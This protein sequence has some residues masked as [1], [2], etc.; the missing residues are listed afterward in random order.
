MER[1]NRGPIFYFC[2]GAL[3]SLVSIEAKIVRWVPNTNTNNPNNW[4]TGQVPCSN[5]HIHF[6]ATSPS[7]Y[8][9]NNLTTLEIVL[10][11]NGEVIL[12]DSAVLVF[13]ASVSNDATCKEKNVTFVGVEAKSWFD[14]LN[15]CEMSNIDG[16][17]LSSPPDRLD[18]DRV[19]CSSDSVVFPGDASYLVQLENSVDIQVGMLTIANQA[20]TTQTFQRYLSSEAGRKQFIRESGTSA[21][22]LTVLSKTCSQTEPT[23]C[24]CANSQDKQIKERVCQV[25]NG[26]CGTP[27]CDQPL[28]VDEHCCQ[29][30]GSVLLLEFGATTRLQLID[31]LAKRTLSDLGDKKEGVKVYVSKSHDEEHIQIVVLDSDG[32]DK[33][34]PLG[35]DIKTK[36]DADMSDKKRYGITHITIRESG[37]SNS[38]AQAQTGYKEMGA[39]NIVGIVIGLIA[40]LVIVLLAIYCTSSSRRPLK[41]FIP[42][43]PV[44]LRRGSSDGRKR[45]ADMELAHSVMFNNSVIFEAGGFDNPNFDPSLQPQRE[46]VE[47]HPRPAQYRVSGAAEQVDLGTAKGSFANPVYGRSVPQ[48]SKSEA[49]V[50]ATSQVSPLDDQSTTVQ[51]TVQFSHKALKD[52]RASKQSPAKSLLTSILSR[53]M[54]AKLTDDDN[55]AT[56]GQTSDDKPEHDTDVT[57]SKPARSPKKSRKEAGTAGESESKPDEGHEKKSKKSKTGSSSQMHDKLVEDS[58]SDQDNKEEKKQESKKRKEK[59]SKKKDED[60]DGGDLSFGNP[61]YM[62]EDT[63]RIKWEVQDQAA[64]AQEKPTKDKS[65]KEKQSKEKPKKEKPSK[66]KPSSFANP[67]FE[68]KP[69][70]AVAESA[71]EEVR[72]PAAMPVESAGSL[73]Q[74]DDVVEDESH[75]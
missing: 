16:A 4:N 72:G 22:T 61:L 31:N 37:V 50:I 21:T 17:C 40:L 9:Q 41:D 29:F 18:L 70:A 14:P 20:Y 27:A 59:K 48:Y 36:L 74:L 24:A 51:P 45:T 75:A 66:E 49:A 10:P 13:P 42:D 58:S 11:N 62:K 63:A 57:T 54:Q 2:I 8:V 25:Q 60:V 23:G 32:G 38:S 26:R 56:P 28:S 15:W 52:D 68:E 73:V 44:F 69:V 1:F 46:G 5:E 12:G 65:S 67:L 71:P 35:R 43:V 33:A 34:K 53:G 47:I 19:P 64:E 55:K 7:I 30:C 6:P 39:G 3:L